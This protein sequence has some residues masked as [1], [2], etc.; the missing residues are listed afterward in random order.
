[1]KKN[2]LVYIIILLMPLIDL[3]SSLSN[4]IMPNIIS[5]GTIV[6]GLIIVACVLYVL[7]LSKSKYR[8]ISILYFLIIFA[9]FILYFVFKIDLLSINNFVQES[10][11]FIWLTK[12]F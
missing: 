6:K 10:N 9:Y 4:R 3:L 12:L 5:A 1:M 7:L 8:R 11:Y 2:N